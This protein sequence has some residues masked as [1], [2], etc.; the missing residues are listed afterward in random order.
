MEEPKTITARQLEEALQTE[1][2]QLLREQCDRAQLRY[3][4]LTTEERDQYLLEVIETLANTAFEQGKSVFANRQTV[5]TESLARF[6]RWFTHSM[7]GLEP[8]T[9]PVLDYCWRANS[10]HRERRAKVCDAAA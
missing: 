9:C 7:R 1:F 2:S 10:A 3:Q 4:E 8:R 5:F 6:L